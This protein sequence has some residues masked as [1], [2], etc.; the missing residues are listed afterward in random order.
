LLFGRFL[1]RLFNAVRPH[2]AEPDLA[3]EID[4]H[5]ALIEDEY[6]RAGAT[7]RDARRLARRAFG[8]VELT[9]DRHRDARSF[10]WFDDLGQDI[11]YTW[12]SFARDPGFTAVAVLTLALGIGA[13]TAIFSVVNAVLLRPLPYPHADEL[14]LPS[15]N[16]PAADSPTRRPLHTEGLELGE[17]LEIQRRARAFSYAAAY[18]TAL[19]TVA[20][21]TDS[22]REEIVRA[23]AATFPML[24]VPP[25]VGR[26]LDARDEQPG[27]RVVLLSYG[28][29][30]RYFG[31]DAGV[32]GRTLAFNGDRFAGDIALGERYTIVGVMP[33]LF[34]YPD[35]NAAMWTTLVPQ[36]PPD[37]RPRRIPVIARLA[38]G[39]T[40]EAAADEVATIAAGVRH[41]SG[42]S[43][44][45]DGHHPRFEF[46]RWQ[47]RIG[48]PVRTTLLMLTGA[49]GL[50]L[51]IACGNVAGLQ[52]ARATTRRRE[53]AVRAALGAGRGR[54]IR[55]VLT[56]SVLL[57]LVAGATGA[58]LAYGGVRLLRILATSMARVDLGS[59]AALPRLDAIAISSPVLVFTVAVSLLTGVLFGLAPAVGCAG[60]NPI[61]DLRAAASATTPISGFRHR[62]A[63]QG[64]LIIA[65]IAM[66]TML[67]VGGGLL[68]RSF[69]K[70]TRVELG[71]S[72]V[73]VTTF[74]VILAGRQPPPARLKAFAEDLVSRLRGAPGVDAVAYANQLPMVSL[75][76]SAGGFR[77]TPTPPPVVP[78]A[79]ASPDARVV[80][81]DYF[82]AMNIRVSAGRSFG[83]DD[84]AGQPR[85]LLINQALARREFPDIDP[86]GQT[87][88]I[89]RQP[90]PWQIVG[91][92]ENVR[93]FGLDQSPEPQ[94][95]AD[96]RQWPESGSMPVFPAGAYFVVRSRNATAE[97]LSR[98]RDAVHDLEPQASLQNVATMDQIVSNWLTRPRLYAV[99]LSIFAAVAVVLAGIGIYGVVAYTVAQR[100][101]EIGI[102][103]ALGAERSRIIALVLRQSLVLTS[104]GI[105]LG[106]SGAAAATRNLQAMLFGL[107]PL[108]P[109]TFAGVAGA[110]ACLAMLASYL[111]AH[112]ATRMDPL[113]ALRCE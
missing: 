85:V 63:T 42:R 62:F 31:G 49:A 33:P 84:R 14:V 8:G 25:L 79:S 80:S 24:G 82:R 41:A 30:Q 111:P 22:V 46:G 56:E 89:G 96:V 18:E 4:S 67:L 39:V 86:I 43:S 47:D 83:G 37:G 105:A 69:V 36:L 87:V 65:E 19:V 70:L 81:R 5:L 21:G 55:Q 68:M 54:V 59:V 10:S 35:D 94:F 104:I 99:L 23:T 77:R 113:A 91:I 38:P 1:H 98:V 74:Q 40:P 6:R 78:P 51:L 66:A 29:W 72:P 12:R 17:F 60:A 45:A 15:E 102:R 2:R 110:F 108:D 7:D 75:R 107:T 48:A 52:L 20:G 28:A 106:L 27:A 58:L 93:Q 3:R 76:D 64:A 11:R 88:Y 13:T 44:Y 109:A 103:M 97:I 26:W 57:S 90:E 16:V 61:E 34:R 50:V 71:Y 100:T 112:R 101:R 95:F 9:K 32:I 92:V 53:M 73:N